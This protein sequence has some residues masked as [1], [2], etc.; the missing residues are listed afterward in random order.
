VT[1]FSLDKYNI[2]VADDCSK[3]NTV[4]IVKNYQK[5]YPDKIKFIANKKN[6]GIPKNI[7]Q[8]RCA[9]DGRY[10]I[11]LSGD[12]YWIDDNKIQA[13]IS[14]LDAH[15]EYIIACNKTEIRHGDST[16]CQEVLPDKKFCNRTYSLED[17]EKGIYPQMHG[18][19]IRNVYKDEK[20]QKYLYQSQ[21][22][23]DKVD[24]E[25]DV[26]LFLMLGDF[27]VLD[28]LTDV[29]RIPEDKKNSHNYNSV[30]NYYEIDKQEIDILNKMYKEW[31][32]KID[33]RK[34]YVYHLSM[35]I[36]HM[37]KD[38]NKGNRSQYRKL[39][40]SVPSEYKKTWFGGVIGQSY[41]RLF[42]NKM[43]NVF[44]K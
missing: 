11:H 19:A 4:D 35:A 32:D 6:M 41:K 8:G 37:L 25:V 28:I 12:D 22:I 1:E 42:T 18:F 38:K 39:I 14:F 43:R 5:K 9:C 31:G 10:I 26:V 40:S 13:M 20:L 15:H 21:I 34:I 23:S 24:D 33:F 30:F 27:Y 17:Y 29:Y 3:D 2:I 7:Y 44:S 16:V 36:A